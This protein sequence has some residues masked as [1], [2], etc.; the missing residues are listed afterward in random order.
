MKKTL[1]LLLVVLSISSY[2]Q[3]Q[4]KIDPK[5]Q[6]IKLTKELKQ[7]ADSL[8]YVTKTLSSEVNQLSKK[9]DIMIEDQHQLNS[10]L[11]YFKSKEDFYKTALAEQS[12]FYV[13]TVS[14][15][16]F[17]FGLISWGF[18]KTELLKLKRYVKQKIKV[19]GQKMKSQYDLIEETRNNVSRTIGNLDASIARKRYNQNKFSLSLAHR[20]SA[21]YYLKTFAIFRNQL[22]SK[23]ETD[24]AFY[25]NL[26]EAEKCIN[27]LKQITTGASFIYEQELFNEKLDK[28]KRTLKAMEMFELN[29]S[30][31]IISKIIIGLNFLENKFK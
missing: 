10:E 8:T 23:K 29:E 27:K 1:L 26:V 11:I 9:L 31:I 4:K 16:L 2:A 24:L 19:H 6:N 15:I 30:Q 25:V 3:K 20:L 5:N 22:D 21:A 14:V 13:L 12:K 28:Y 18:Y 17:L 7:K